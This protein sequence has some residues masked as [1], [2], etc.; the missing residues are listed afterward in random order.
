MKTRI[1]GNSA[2]L[3]VIAAAGLAV[4]FASS[5][6]SAQAT[7]TWVSGVGD[8]VNP[9]SRTAPCKTFAGAISKTA[10]GG[11]IDA[12]DPG[13]F[14]TVS[15]TKSITIDGGMGNLAGVLASS[16]TGIT[17]NIPNIGAID[18]V[19][20]RNL[21]I[22]GARNTP[23]PG[24]TG[25][26]ILSVDQVTIDNITVDGFGTAGISV[27]PTANPVSVMIDR[28]RLTNNAVGLSVNG[29]G[30][31]ATAR[32]SDSTVQQNTTG[33][34]VTGGGSIISFNNNRLNGN[35][36]DGAPTST[37]YQR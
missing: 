10:A 12:L 8:D 7:R 19:I 28:T 32:L 35:G 17:I 18:T 20:L 26:R 34:A 37:V 14:G 13:A 30:A 1:A 29:T 16:T 2:K 27:A 31:A 21:S 23:S 15:I 6:A 25:I 5:L 4:V 36:T 22:N 24:V 9:C 33:L 11:E 3:A